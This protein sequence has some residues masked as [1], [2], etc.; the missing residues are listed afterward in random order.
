[1][2]HL[3]FLFFI[4]CNLSSYAQFDERNALQRTQ[5]YNEGIKQSVH[6]FDSVINQLTKQRSQNKLT[7]AVFLKNYAHIERE[8][9]S[10]QQIV[11]QIAEKWTVLQVQRPGKNIKNALA[12]VLNGKTNSAIHS[13][14]TKAAGLNKLERECLV[15][16]HRFSGQIEKANALLPLQLRDS[17]EN[18]WKNKFEPFSEQDTLAFVLKKIYIAQRFHEEN[19]IE[20]AIG[21]LL[22]AQKWNDYRVLKDNE[23]Q[24]IA[25]EIACCLGRLQL[26]KSDIDN[27]FRNT[28]ISA[29]IYKS[30]V[31][32]NVQSEYAAALHLLALVYRT[33]GANREAD[34]IFKKVFVEYEQLVK[35]YPERYQ[36]LF[37]LAWDDYAQVQKYFDQNEAYDNNL[38]KIIDWRKQLSLSGYPFYQYDMGRNL[39]LLGQKLM[40]TD[41]KIFLAQEQWSKAKE[42]LEP[43]QKRLPML[44][45]NELCGVLYKLGGAKIALKKRSEAL[46]F[47]IQSLNVRT[48]LYQLAP[49]LN[50]KDYVD[51]LTQNAT[52]NALEQKKEVALLQLD[53]A[54]KVVEEL[55][56]RKYADEIKKFKKDVQTH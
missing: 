48:Q 34:T 42:V 26:G 23:Q 37:V 41:V 11:A 24:K 15:D 53:M 21:T 51:V 36:P 20:S 12:L 43:L 47:F 6:Y 13:L 10:Q 35:Q 17:M 39:N 25:A 56:D 40:N 55:G 31:N 18:I 50:N 14:N 2:K 22:E 54:I 1:M 4:L 7:E 46:P 8:Y 5:F 45:G 33:A 9:R 16:L 28:K 29:D 44:A 49:S 19:E 52:L 30:L 38:R 32:E 3:F 27:A